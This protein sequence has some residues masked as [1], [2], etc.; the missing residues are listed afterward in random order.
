MAAEIRDGKGR[1]H[2]IGI[3]VVLCE[4][5]NL[6]LQREIFDNLAKFLRW[7]GH[8]L[9]LCSWIGMVG[10]AWC[11]TEG[12]LFAVDGT[13]RCPENL[14]DYSTALVAVKVSRTLLAAYTKG[15]SSKREQRG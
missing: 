11:R 14:G 13:K 3:G 6:T 8:A 10:F 7:G 12:R 4:D 5:R 1:T 9:A 15:V 2:R